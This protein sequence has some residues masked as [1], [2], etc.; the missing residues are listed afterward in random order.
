MKRITF[1]CDRC[2]KKVGTDETD[3]RK[4]GV[5]YITKT[6]DELFIFKLQERLVHPKM[7]C[8]ECSKDFDKWMEYRK[9]T[10]DTKNEKS[11]QIRR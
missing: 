7:V 1:I 2:G 9:G 6:D 4:T 8:K 3:L 11:L 5:R 10:N